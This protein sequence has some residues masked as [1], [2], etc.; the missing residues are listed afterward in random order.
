MEGKEI[1]LMA[2]SPRSHPPLLRLYK[3]PRF[4]DEGKLIIDPAKDEV[5]NGY[6]ARGHHLRIPFHNRP[7]IEE[8]REEPAP[9]KIRSF[10]LM[11]EESQGE[12]A[13]SEG[14]GKEADRKTE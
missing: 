11:D 10:V 8:L 1:E 13:G 9:G 4:P 5:K 3:G 14:T 12:T 6:S 2:R 7:M